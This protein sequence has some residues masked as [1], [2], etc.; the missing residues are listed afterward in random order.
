MRLCKCITETKNAD[1]SCD[2]LVKVDGQP[3]QHFYKNKV[4]YFRETVPYIGR[5]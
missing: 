4:D 3:T 2:F 1:G 5:F